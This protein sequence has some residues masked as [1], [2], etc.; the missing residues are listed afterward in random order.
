MSMGP[1]DA[2]V[3]ERLL[4]ATIITKALSGK[5]GKSKDSVVRAI[6]KFFFETN[7]AYRKANYLY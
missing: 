7:S 4:K 3:Y 5:M 1:A 6:R 2:F